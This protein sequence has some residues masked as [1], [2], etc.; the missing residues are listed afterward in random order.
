MLDDPGTTDSTVTT[1]SRPAPPPHV[2]DAFGRVTAPVAAAAAATLALPAIAI[3]GAPVHANAFYV[4]IAFAL[5]IAVWWL[6]SRVEFPPWSP[7]PA[8]AIAAAAM[9][10]LAQASYPFAALLVAPMTA[11]A[12]ALIR[13]QPRFALTDW[14]GPAVGLAVLAGVRIALGRDAAM[15]AGGS[16][17]FLAALAALGRGTARQRPHL[18]GA[19][20]VVLGVVVALFT[21]AYI[22]A[23]TPSATWFGGLVHHGP[24]DQNNVALTFDDG[25]NPPF[26]L[27]IARILDDNGVK[28]TFFTVGKALEARP[29]VSKALMAD[30]QL[31]ANHSYHH[32]AIRW[33]DPG[34]QELDSTQDAFKRTLGVCPAFFRPPHGT[35]TPLMAKA[36]DDNGMTMVTWDDSAGDWATD[37]GA[38]VAQRILDKVKPG[39]IILLHDGIDGNI[40]ADRSVILQALPIILDGLRERGLT[41]VRLDELLGKPGYLESC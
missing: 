30:G 36:V 22:G 12:V 5:S 4:V 7:V 27:E 41:P 18:R 39:S 40:G 33:L 20:A 14:A 2:L 26:S 25:P 10:L 6:A 9:W 19:L 11:I 34:Y 3:A 32:D 21:T 28:G 38:L 16:L 35:H 17:L 29:D 23:T 37:D 31:L 13:R 1:S 8:I 15:A 24:R